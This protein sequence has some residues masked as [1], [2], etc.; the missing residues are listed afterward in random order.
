M[1]AL[2]LQLFFSEQIGKQCGAQV[3]LTRGRKDNHNILIGKGFIFLKFER[4]RNSRTGR[5]TGE[6]AFFIHQ[7]TRGRDGFFVSDGDHFI[8]QLQIQVA[9]NESRANTLDFMRTR[10]EL[11]ARQCLGDN[12]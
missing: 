4:C 3:T 9:R 8:D 11:F 7:T 12:R 10:L 5:D 1:L 2:L 6:N